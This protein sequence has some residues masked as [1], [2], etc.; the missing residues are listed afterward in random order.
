MLYAEAMTLPYF[1]LHSSECSPASP[2]RLIPR[3]KIHRSVP[4]FS[5]QSI[6]RAV[7]TIESN[8]VYMTRVQAGAGIT[9]IADR[10][11]DKA[12]MLLTNPM[13]PLFSPREVLPG[14]L[15]D[16]KNYSS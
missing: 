1:D 3:G 15:S 5:F 12:S 9:P 8:P 13:I 7:R 11:S 16:S 4:I 14:S 6:D 10:P 2:F